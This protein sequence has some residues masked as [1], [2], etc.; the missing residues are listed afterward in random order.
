VFSDEKKF[1]LDGPDGNQFYWHDIRKEPQYYSKQAMGG[2]SVMVWAGFGFCGKTPIKI[3]NGRQNSSDYINTLEECLLPFGEEIG[4]Q[5][6]IYQ[7]D[8][9]SIHT[10][11]TVKTWFRDQHIRVLEWPAKSPDLNPIENLW[12]IMVRTVYRNGKQYN[13]I[14]ELETAIKD[15]WAELDESIFKKLADSMTNRLVEVL[16]RKGNFTGY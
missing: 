16:K 2:G 6:W 14:R 13:N 7:Q 15:C 12:G 1:N 11:G 8:N 10:A 4:G 3:L 5:D 9:A